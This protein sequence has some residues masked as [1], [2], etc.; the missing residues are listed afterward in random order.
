M[1]TAEDFNQAVISTDQ[2]LQGKAA[3]VRI[4]NAGGQPDAGANIRIRGGSSL[5]AKNSPLIV[6]DGIPVDNGGV[7]GTGNPFILLNPNDIESFSILKDAS[8]TAIYGSRASNGVLIVTTKKGTSGEVKYNF[9]ARTSISDIR[10]ENQ[11]NVMDGNTF[12]RFAQEYFPDDLGLLGV[13]VGS[14]DTDEQVSQII[15]TPLGDRA[16][17][18][19]DWQDAIFRTAISHDYNFSA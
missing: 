18:N 3:G 6:I 14:V 8:A 10:S 1:V 9:S 4:T 13:P 2:L 12:V 17:Y 16:I 19:T 15:S 7:A 11:V 5:S